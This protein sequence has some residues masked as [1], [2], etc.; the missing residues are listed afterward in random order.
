M[1]WSKLTRKRYERSGGRY[2][3]DLTDAEWALIGTP[4]APAQDH[5]Q[6]PHDKPARRVRRDPLQGHHGLP[7][8]DVAQRLSA[9]LDGAGIFPRVAQ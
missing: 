7:M 6:A 1:A 2:A 3:S 5:R 4:D 8:A 9:G